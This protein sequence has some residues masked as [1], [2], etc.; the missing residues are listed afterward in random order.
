MSGHY[1]ATGGGV[2]HPFA[3][4]GYAADSAGMYDTDTANEVCKFRFHT[5][6]RSSLSEKEENHASS[7]RQT[8]LRATDT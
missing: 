1:R 5:F 6:P 3:A 4:H 2:G 8:R 7:K